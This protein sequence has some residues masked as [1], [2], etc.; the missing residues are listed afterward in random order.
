MTKINNQNKMTIYTLCFVI[1]IDVLTIGLV[2]PIFAAL[3]NDPHGI[4]PTN[5]P[6]ETR[7]MLYAL[8]ISL[9][10]FALLFGSPIL[11]EL[12]DRWGRKNVLLF[13]LI[14]VFM[15]CLL[16][17]LSFYLSSM[18]LLFI[19]RLLVMLMD[20][21][22]A[23]AQAAI[24]D[25]SEPGNKVKN[26][27]YISIAGTFGFIVGPILGGILSDK[28][29]CSWFGYQTPFWAAAFIAL[30]NAFVLKFIFTD[31]RTI[32]QHIPASW[33]EVF[34][35]LFKG[36]FDKRYRKLCFVF[37]ALQFVWSGVFQASSL[38]L[39]QKFHYSTSWLG[40]FCGFIGVV[41]SFF[42]IVALNYFLK[43][44]STLNI[45]R[46]GSVL[47][48]FGALVYAVWPHEL[49]AI[50]LG[51]IP[52]AGGMALSYNT[53]LALFSD[54]VAENEQGKVMGITVGLVAIAWLLAGLFIGYMTPIGYSWT[55]YGE[56]VVAALAVLSLFFTC[57][58]EGASK[59]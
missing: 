57:Q 19:S 59:L 17:V 7:N 3:F 31:T 41:F 56:V 26:M 51:I 46:I 21:S 14:G 42:L 24:V 12:S 10:M 33:S 36:F 6:I 32:Q 22:Q 55:F 4:L 9:P 40:Y 45:A 20:G 18:V 27:S 47:L 38:L 5:T 15:S 58:E 43:L 13:S 2:I 52:I 30:I 8:I 39:A 48:C 54:A 50:W 53:L 1:F 23:I 44:F 49:F 11:G 16:S 28:G 37:I 35:R 29:L 34:Q 25:I